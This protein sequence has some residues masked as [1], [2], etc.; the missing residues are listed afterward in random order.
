MPACSPSG[1]ILFAF[2]RRGRYR[3]PRRCC[4]R[5]DRRACE[6]A[7][8]YRLRA[9][10]EIAKPSREVAASWGNP[11]S[12]RRRHPYA[13]PSCQ[14]LATGCLDQRNETAE[15]GL[16]A[17]NGTGYHAFRISQGGIG[18][19][20]LQFGDLFR[21][22]A[23]RSLNAS[24]SG[25]G[26]SP[27]RRSRSRSSAQFGIALRT[28]PPRSV[29][30]ITLQWVRRRTSRPARIGGTP[31]VDLVLIEE[32][33]GVALDPDDREYM[34]SSSFAVDI[35]P[36]SMKIGSLA[37]AADDPPH[38]SVEDPISRIVLDQPGVAP[39]GSDR[40]ISLAA[41]AGC[42]Q[43]ATP[44]PRIMSSRRAGVDPAQRSAARRQ[45][46]RSARNA[47]PAASPR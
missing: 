15:L 12:T 5:E 18:G 30:V 3:L 40:A 14:R 2:S 42:P 4:A 13:D 44:R 28:Q 35:G 38:R 23:V 27:D 24:I 9:A 11:G 10:V 31:R 37:A 29:R 22:S 46:T 41:P 33:L 16:R 7:R 39:T 8:F 32:Q 6:T 47:G 43:Q 36:A 17:G 19:R 45:R 25:K 34:R 20:D 21:M 26:A 1:K